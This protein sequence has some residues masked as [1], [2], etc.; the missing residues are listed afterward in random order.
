M[1]CIYTINNVIYSLNKPKTNGAKST[2]DLNSAI[3]GLTDKPLG[4][5]FLR[6]PAL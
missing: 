3:L 6:R 5:G 4:F 1:L 2:Y